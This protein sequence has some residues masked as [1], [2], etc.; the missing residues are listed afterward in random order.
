MSQL[1]RDRPLLV[2]A[3]ILANVT[4]SAWCIFNDPVINND[5]VTYLALAKYMQQGQ[6]AD[7]FAY[8]SW[9]FYSIFIMVTS[10]LFFVDIETAAYI[11]NTLLATSLTLAFVCIVAEL[12]DNDR[13]LILLAALVILLFPSINKYR[14]FIIR[15][16]GY[17]SCYL[18]SLFFIFKFCRTFDK[19]HLGGW[20]A[21][22]VLSCLFRFEGIVFLLI[23][24]YFLLL[25][26]ATNLPHR[27]TV[28]IALSGALVSVSAALVFWYL[29]DKYAAML[30]MAARTGED[31]NG[32]ADLFFAN[33]KQQVGQEALGASAYLKAFVAGIGVV[34]YE[35]MRRMAVL[36]FVFSVYGYVK[37]LVLHNALQR[38]VWLVFVGT[39]LVVLI[40]FS[41]YTSFLVSRY[42][43]ATALTLLLLAPF[44]MQHLWRMSW[45]GGRTIRVM[46]IVVAIVLA[47]ISAD[48]LTQ[49]TNKLHLKTAGLWLAE[50]VSAGERVYSNDKLIIYYADRN[51]E[52][53][54]KHLYST[55]MLYEF[56]QTNQVRN[57]DFIAFNLDNRIY[58]EASLRQTLIYTWG[59]PAHIIEAGT[60][61]FVVIFDLRAKENG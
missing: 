4:L 42:T 32:I 41:L 36:Y 3:I 51:P 34:F 47:G 21:F 29:N 52:E 12:S 28:L 31:I 19:R 23:A 56:H 55:D 61:Q 25:F 58:R 14:S 35:L 26:S 54:L 16:F 59:Q 6:W 10:K 20:L 60:A 45:A 43:L 22:A 30:T 27:R 33:I 18:W 40:G 11:L 53:N 9:P 7:A 37:N 15:D 2:L 5:G 1:Y 49:T 38:K 13:N 8:Y 48:R 39:N 46:A 17:L 24:P 57:Y 44:A 50:N